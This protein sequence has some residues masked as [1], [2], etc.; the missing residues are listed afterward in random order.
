MG[1]SAHQL[2]G[3]EFGHC[4]QDFA[5]V[6]IPYYIGSAHPGAF[7]ERH[8]GTEDNY[9]VFLVLHERE[10]LLQ[11][12]PLVGD[13]ASVV[14]PGLLVGVGR[15]RGGSAVHVVH[16]YYVGVAAVEGVV[17]GAEVVGEELRGLV[18]VGARGGVVV[19]AYALEEREPAGAY[20]HVG[21]SVAHRVPHIG[22][23]E[24]DVSQGDGI[25]VPVVSGGQAFI[26]GGLYVGDGAGV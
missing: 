20:L 9:L 24:N 4:S 22:G 3:V 5:A 13:E 12:L 16:Y 10:V 15:G 18:V 11:P 26:D 2:G 8:V 7:A 19:V 25:D 17:D 14:V 23:I 1:M 6:A 21:H